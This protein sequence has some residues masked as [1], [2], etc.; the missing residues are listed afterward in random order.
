MKIS[1]P[2]MGPLAVA[3]EIS[4]NQPETL[5]SGEP[6]ACLLVREKTRRSLVVNTPLQ[7]PD[8]D[9]SQDQSLCS[10]QC[11]YARQLRVL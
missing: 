5:A 2:L 1:D 6:T 9:G 3:R 8:S 7:L 10:R 11:G 4:H